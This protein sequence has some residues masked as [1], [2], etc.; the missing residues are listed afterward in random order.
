M[1]AGRP[2]EYSQE[3]ADLICELLA[4]GKS[5]RTI[6]D[7]E[8]MPNRATVFR[9]LA[10]H[11]EFSDQ[12][13]HARDAQ[14]DVLFDEVLDIADDA[15]NDWMKRNVGED[16]DDPWVLNGDHVQRTRLR[17][18]ARKWMAGK[19]RPKKYGEKQEIE[20]SGSIKHTLTE[21]TDEELAAIAAGKG[22]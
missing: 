9:W 17:I 13:A 2:T 16:E 7:A 22:A 5:L 3:I 11:K 20:H 21:M 6:C 19:L 8:D 1:P 15:R 14:A 12:Y 18:D 10:K 4:D